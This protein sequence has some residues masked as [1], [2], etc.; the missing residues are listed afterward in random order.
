MTEQTKENPKQVVPQ[1]P[2]MKFPKPVITKE[3]KQIK[4]E[5]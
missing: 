5:G 4:K 3:F 2:G 1:I